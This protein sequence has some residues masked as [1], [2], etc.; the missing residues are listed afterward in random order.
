MVDDN[1]RLGIYVVK[2]H[3]RNLLS[4]GE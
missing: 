1:L 2:T 4:S 3:N